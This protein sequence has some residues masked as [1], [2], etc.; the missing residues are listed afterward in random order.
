[1]G[2]TVESV[3]LMGACKGASGLFLGLE[4]DVSQ[5]LGLDRTIGG[6]EGRCG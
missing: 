4:R 3:L 2:S 1:M 5:G 6:Y